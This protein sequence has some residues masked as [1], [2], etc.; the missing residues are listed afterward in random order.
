MSR[1]WQIDQRVLE[2]IGKIA[3]GFGS[4]EDRSELLS[5]QYERARL[6]RPWIRVPE[7]C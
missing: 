1:E 5:L 7:G 2:I 4:E 6:M 3:R